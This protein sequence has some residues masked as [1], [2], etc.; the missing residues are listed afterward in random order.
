MPQL[1][2]SVIEAHLTDGQNL[3]VYGV[4]LTE[5]TKDELIACL[6][7]LYANSQPLHVS[8]RH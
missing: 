6:A 8:T 2:K 3:S 7:M 5:M 4:P 1:P